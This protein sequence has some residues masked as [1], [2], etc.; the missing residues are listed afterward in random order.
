MGNILTLTPAL[1][2]TR[3]DLDRALTDNRGAVSLESKEGNSSVHGFGFTVHGW[4]SMAGIETESPN[5]RAA[6]SS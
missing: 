1:T 5:C 6:P 4:K 2:I 3:E